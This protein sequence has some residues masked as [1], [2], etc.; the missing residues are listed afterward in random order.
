MAR[1]NSMAW[2][3]DQ[4]K[5]SGWYIDGFIL[6]NTATYNVWMERNRKIHEQFKIEMVAF[7][8]V[9]FE[10]RSKILVFA[11]PFSS[12]IH[13]LAMNWELEAVVKI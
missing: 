5:V 8:D 13:F 2:Q 1:F 6:E 11:Q 4:E 7:A 9:E 10:V 3:E 12:F